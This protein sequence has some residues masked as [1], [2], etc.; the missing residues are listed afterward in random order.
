MHVV[1]VRVAAELEVLQ[2]SRTAVDPV[3]LVVHLAPARGPVTA[4][5]YAV[6]GAGHHGPAQPG[7]RGAHAPADV[8]RLAAGAGDDATDAAVTGQPPGRFAA[9]HPTPVQ[10]DALCTGVAFKRLQ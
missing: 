9:D 1:V 7:R 10:V 2:A 4:F 6:T 3:L 5:L 8:Q